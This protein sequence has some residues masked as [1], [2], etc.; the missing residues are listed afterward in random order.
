MKRNIH[1]FLLK[2]LYLNSR[3][4][5]LTGAF[6]LQ[7]MRG[8]GVVVLKTVESCG[9]LGQDTPNQSRFSCSRRAGQDHKGED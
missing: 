7:V 4:S 9:P 3:L 6:R 1:F 5:S 8:G 2:G